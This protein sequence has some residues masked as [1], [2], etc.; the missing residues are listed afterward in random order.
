MKQNSTER[1]NRY[2]L[3]KKHVP[4]YRG[5]TVNYMSVFF[6]KRK[7]NRKHESLEVKENSSFLGH[8]ALSRTETIR[9]S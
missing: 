6:F 5:F 8:L 3:N 7:R 2:T 4:A 1:R 9:K